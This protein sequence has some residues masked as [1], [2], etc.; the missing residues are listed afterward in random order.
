[1][2]DDC[3]YN[4][5]VLKKN[6]RRNGFC[7]CFA[8][9]LL[10]IACVLLGIF[11]FVGCSVT[12]YFGFPDNISGSIIKPPVVVV[13]VNDVIIDSAPLV[14]VLNKVCE[15][16]CK[17]VVVRIDSPGGSVGSSEEIYR[18]VKRLRDRGK[19]VVASLGNTAA[20][21]G[22]YVACGAQE[23]ITNAGT[24]TGSIGVISNGVIIQQLLQKLGVSPQTDASGELKETGTPM[25]PATEKEKALTKCVINDIYLQF[26]KVVLTA[27]NK[28]ID[29]ALTT[30]SAE[31]KS[32]ISLGQDETTETKSI[33]NIEDVARETSV[34]LQ[35]TALLQQI[36][37]GRII[38]GRQA[39]VLGLADGIG[40]LNDAVN[41]A[42]VLANIGSE[43]HYVV[44]KPVG[45]I[46]EWFFSKTQTLFVKVITGVLNR[47]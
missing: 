35:S 8:F 7:C 2:S 29:D 14:K 32:I 42:G 4:Q 26:F 46:E 43:P 34:S 15:S 23:I 24:V 28:S 45:K 21:G 16:S 1:M 31:I 27:R 44:Q 3:G 17:A 18:A 25:R 38:T 33:V 47:L 13:P 40:G 6:K 11:V 41:R 39:V 12:K 20:S 22:Y 36:A 37:D 5:E 19:V 9:F 30:N 10:L